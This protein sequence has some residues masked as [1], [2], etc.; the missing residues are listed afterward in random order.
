[1][2]IMTGGD[3]SLY[4]SVG[5]MG[6]V[7]VFWSFSGFLLPCIFVF[8]LQCLVPTVWDRRL[9]HLRSVRLLSIVDVMMRRIADI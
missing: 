7:H 1:M 9:S 5:P 6:I 8:L 2:H 4:S 3:H